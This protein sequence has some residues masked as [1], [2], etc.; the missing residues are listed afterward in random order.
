M[1]FGAPRWKIFTLLFYSPLFQPYQ[2][3]ENSIFPPFPF[4]P[5]QTDNQ[6][7]TCMG[8]V[9][10]LLFYPPSFQ[11][12]QIREN[13]IFSSF[14][15]PPNK[16]GTYVGVCMVQVGSGFRVEKFP[17]PPNLPATTYVETNPTRPTCVGLDQQ[18]GLKYS[19]IVKKGFHQLFKT[20]FKK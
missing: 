2:I 18:I 16:T 4:P 12:Y 14:P 15:F 1:V 7:S 20:F 8:H 11:T 19:C 17:T 10:T 6:V 13:S 3:R 9:H 5:N